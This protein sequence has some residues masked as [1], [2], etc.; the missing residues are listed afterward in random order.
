VSAAEAVILQTVAATVA[1]S[2][3]SLIGVFFLGMREEIL[4]RVIDQLV[5]F[6]AGALLGTALMHM[7]PEAFEA[8][9]PSSLRVVVAGVLVFFITERFLYWRH[10]HKAECK[11]H[12]FVYL[13]LLGDGIHNFIDGL[14]IA[15]SFVSGSSLGAAAVL[16]VLAHEVPQEIGDFG[17]LVYGGLSRR[18]ALIY[19]LL[20]A[21]TAVLGGLLGLFASMRT[22][23][24]VP[25]LVPFAAGGFI[26]VACSDLIPEIH[27]ERSFLKTTM[28]LISLL[29]GLAATALLAGSH[30]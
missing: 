21:L 26:Y 30:C 12:T 29:L 24:F 2:L 7:I 23:A 5:A 10:C 11:T 17:V 3:V 13:N 19:N 16:S 8:L 20:S 18:R 14:V 25:A 28:Q 4:G 9:G 22:A 27:K 6:A 15:A 1:V